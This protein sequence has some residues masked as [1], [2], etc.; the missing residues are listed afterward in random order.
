MNVALSSRHTV[1]AQHIAGSGPKCHNFGAPH[2]SEAYRA[3]TREVTCKKCLKALA[4]EAEAA[5]VVESPAEVVESLAEVVDRN[6]KIWNYTGTGTRAHAFVQVSADNPI[7]KRALCRPDVRVYADG[8][9]FMSQDDVNQICI[10]CLKLAT[11]MW[12]RAEASMQ[13]APEVH[14]LGYVAPVDEDDLD[15]VIVQR[16]PVDALVDL[17]TPRK[18]LVT[19]PGYDR[20]GTVLMDDSFGGGLGWSAEDEDGVTV[21]HTCASRTRAVVSL[22]RAAGI[23]A[24]LRVRVV[25]SFRPGTGATPELNGR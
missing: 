11:V 4:G 19:F 17:V 6:E 16:A 15:E 7:T 14:D 20:T 12:D 25:R 10:R 18:A 3:T 8:L 24:P 13:P 1:H 21:D 2:G 9:G 23:T 22:A 5:E